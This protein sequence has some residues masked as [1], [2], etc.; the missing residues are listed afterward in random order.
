MLVLQL[1]LTPSASASKNQMA[2]FIAGISGN[3]RGGIPVIVNANGKLG[4]TVS[5]ARFKE[6]IALAAKEAIHVLKPVTFHKQEL[7][8][9]SIPQFGLVAEEVE[10]VNPALVARDA[11]GE[12]Y[13]V[14]YE[15]VNAML[16][17][18]FLKEHRNVT[19]LETTV[20]Q[21][22]KKFE[23]KIA[24]QQKEI[25][26]LTTSLKEQAS[27]IQKVSAE[28]EL[29]RPAPQTALNNQ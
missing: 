25:E 11:E 16:L 10:K 19:Q 23:T 13:T 18:E 27:Q 15:A 3:R 24:D 29:R 28:L 22:Q 8:P 9:E 4:T 7:D 1:R 6:A 5:S 17:N 26:A 12:V 2:T 21:Q 14:R 20:A